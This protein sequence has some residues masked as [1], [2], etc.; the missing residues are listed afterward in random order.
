MLAENPDVAKAGMKINQNVMTFSELLNYYYRDETAGEKYAVPTY[1]IFNLAN[2]FSAPYSQAYEYTRDLELVDGGWNSCRI[3]DEQL[4]KLSMDM[5]YGLSSDQVEEH[6]EFFKKL[7]KRWNEL[8][9]SL[10]L[11]CNIYVTVYPDWL[12]N[13]TQD[14]FWDFQSSILYATIAE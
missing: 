1:T 11:Y 2:G 6:L 12:E 7:M 8:L 10:P 13:Y 3:Y 9:P 4:D 14:S 5:V